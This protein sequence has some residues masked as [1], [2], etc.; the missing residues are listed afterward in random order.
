MQSIGKKQTERVSANLP[1]YLSSN[2]LSEINAHVVFIFVI[3]LSQ[4]VL[5][6][7]AFFSFEP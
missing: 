3:F 5:F 7:V 2:C 6:V 1:R 4:I